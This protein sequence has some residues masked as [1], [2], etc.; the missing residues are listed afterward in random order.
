MTKSRKISRHYLTLVGIII[1]GIILRFWNLDLKP[2]WLDEVLTA[3]FSL[4][5]EYHDL[6]LDVVFPLSNL[7]QILTFK[8]GVSCREIAHT[9]ATQSTHPP[10]FFCL[11]YSWLNRIGTDR[12]V[13]A[14]RSLPA[15]MGVAGILAVY[16]LNRFA[17]SKAAA[18][19]AA[20][21]MAVSPFGVYLSQEARHY[22]LPILL[23]TLALLGLLHIQHSLYFHQQ[24]PKPIIWILWGIVNSIGCYVHYF[25]ILVLTAQLLTLTGLMY[26]HRQRLPRGSWVA[27]IL[28]IVGVAISYLPWISVLLADVGRQETDW[29]PPPQTIAPLFQLLV[30]GLLMVI[31]LPVEDQPWWV[32]VSMG[33]L[34][35]GFGGW[36]AWQGFRGVK[37][38][39][40]HSS[41]QLATV[42]LLGFIVFVVLQFL[43]IIYLLSKDISVA[44]RYN[45][46]YFPA[47][48]AL[49]GASLSF[50]KGKRGRIILILGVSLLSSILVVW[51]WVFLKPFH[52]EQVAQTMNKE[53][54]IP[55]I[56]VMGYDNLQDVALGLSFALEIERLDSGI[57]GG[58]GDR[59]LVFLNRQQGY[60]LVWKKVSDLSISSVPPFNVWVAAPGLKR[61]DYPQ[62][63]AIAQQ[64]HCSIDSNDY[65]RVGNFP[66]QLYRC[67][68]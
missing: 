58:V 67:R 62:R 2:L 14:L 37:Q 54:A 7:D 27:L 36:V 65:H 39:L 28:V 56:M 9:L 3:F 32:V 66:Y 26:W 23:I 43:G 64:K 49:L 42:T 53:A 68:D 50:E 17:F 41:T 24:Q 52:P 40:R 31:A 29:L 63:L 57:E 33:G 15:L 8:P 51:N 35:I 20:G 38:L 48:C 60:K 4:G 10:L 30:G 44:P 5:H 34:M 59:S 6:L 1:L 55:M 16:C 21:I 47:I 25:F 11:I 13:W 18:L 61:Q 46:V 19:M 45:F 22:T 12:L